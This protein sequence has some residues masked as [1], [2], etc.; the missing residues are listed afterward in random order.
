[1][2]HR[3]VFVDGQRIGLELGLPHD[4]VGIADI[5]PRPV[6]GQLEGYFGGDQVLEAWRMALDVPAIVDGDHGGDTHGVAGGVGGEICDGFER[7]LRRRSEL[8]SRDRREAQDRGDGNCRPC[9]WP[10]ATILLHAF[11]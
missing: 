2:D 10:A 7:R 8:A 4:V 5:G 9:S 3:F 6:G 11:R 1:M